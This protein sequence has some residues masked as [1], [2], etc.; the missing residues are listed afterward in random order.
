MGAADA[1]EGMTPEEGAEGP[2]GSPEG[3]AQGGCIGGWGG[4]SGVSEILGG[5]GLGREPGEGLGVFSGGL[6]VSSGGPGVSS[7]GLGVWGPPGPPRAFLRSL[8]PLFDILDEGRRGYVLLRDIESR[9]RGAGARDLPGGVLDALRGAA[10][11]GGR[12]TFDGLVAGLRASLLGHD[13]GPHTGGPPP[14]P[15]GSGPAPGG[16]GRPHQRGRTDQR[17]HTITDGVDYSMLQ[18]MRELER[19]KAVLLQGLEMMEQSHQWYQQQIQFVNERQR[20]LGKS[21]NSND[22][23]DEGSV[24]PLGQLLPKLQEVIRCLGELLAAACSGKDVGA[25]FSSSGSSVQAGPLLSVARLAGGN[26]PDHPHNHHHHIIHMLKEQ[27]RLLTKEVTE[28]SE[29]I[30]QL[31]QEKLALIK[32]LFEARARSHHDTSQLD[33]TFM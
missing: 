32:Q 1:N 9:W 3:A 30:T 21:K 4:C 28:K 8:R 33:S 20:Q 14:P 5:Q 12:L 24:S 19:E 22:A 25:S 31:E 23:V 17:R 6:G 10:Q 27:N 18:Q 11:P 26:P 2:A 13:Q 7:G 15:G 16:C 29:R